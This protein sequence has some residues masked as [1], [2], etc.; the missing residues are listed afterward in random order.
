MEF[1]RFEVERT[2]KQTFLPS[3]RCR[4]ERTRYIPYTAVF[5]VPVL[6][7]D[8]FPIA[9]IVHENWDYKEAET[10]V[11]RAFN[12][13]LYSYEPCKSLEG[14]ERDLKDSR[15]CVSDNGYRGDD[16]SIVLAE[17]DDSYQFPDPDRF[18]IRGSAGEVWQQTTEPLYEVCH[19]YNSPVYLCVKGYCDRSRVAT[20]LDIF[21]AN[22]K[23]EAIEYAVKHGMSP[24]KKL[25]GDIEVLMPEMISFCRARKVTLSV[26]M[27]PT[28][29]ELVVPA[30]I[31]D[32]EII[33]YAEN[34]YSVSCHYKL[35]DLKRMCWETHK[36]KVCS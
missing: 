29:F 27:Q 24:D 5:D 10:Q 23:A 11:I 2:L 26:T 8:E 19:G 32:S 7:D 34:F 20:D 28:Q 21:P 22:A 1:K 25:W 33:D 18:V 36:F 4:K 12:G 15:R 14:L 17:A 9:F 16:V 31:S 35:D 30:S 13:R 6:D 3:A